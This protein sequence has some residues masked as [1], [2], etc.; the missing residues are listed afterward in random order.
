MNFRFPVCF[1]YVLAYLMRIGSGEIFFVIN[2]NL[3]HL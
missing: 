2:V 3:E 1:L